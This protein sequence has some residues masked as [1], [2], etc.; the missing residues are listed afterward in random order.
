MRDDSNAAQLDVLCALLTPRNN[1]GSTCILYAGALT[2]T[3]FDSPND[4]GR[5]CQD[6]L[7][8]QRLQIADSRRAL[9]A[10]VQKFNN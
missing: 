9:E 2:Q 1:I 10:D 6:S 8:T 7:A 4:D 5:S 3:T